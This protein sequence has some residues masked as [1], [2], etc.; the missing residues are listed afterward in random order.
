[1]K[2]IKFIYKG[3]EF[4][5]ELVKDDSFVGGSKIIFINEDN[6]TC[7]IASKLLKILYDEK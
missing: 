4:T 7:I 2:K 3:K 5:G 1:M 6:T